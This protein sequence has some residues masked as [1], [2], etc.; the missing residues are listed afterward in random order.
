MPSTIKIKRSGSTA[1]PSAGLA[2]GELAYSWNSNRLYIGTGDETLGIAANIAVIGGKEFTDLVSAATNL[3]TASTI[4]KRDASGNFTAGTI[5][6]TLIGN[7][8][9]ATKLASP[10]TIAFTGDAAASGNFD[11]SANY[12]QI[13]TLADTGVTANSYGS[14]TSIPT[15]T[16]DAKGR[17]TAAGSTPISTTLTLN[18]AGPTTANVVLGTDN[19]TFASTFGITTSIAKTSTTATLT[20][21]I[22]PNFAT[23]ASTGSVTFNNTT[24]ASA[25]NTASVVLSGGLSVT[26]KIYVGDDIIG[27]GPGTSILDGFMADGGTY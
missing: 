2:A 8:D 26:K 20:I 13:L 3:N 25:L 12:S 4:I 6:G 14:S 7:A 11:G 1:F 21:G 27:A 18:A 16:V 24:D 9:T 10:R 23:V 22:A 15:F 17:L 19:L 5:T